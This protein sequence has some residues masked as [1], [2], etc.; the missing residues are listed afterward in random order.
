MRTRCP[1]FTV[2]GEDVE[3]NHFDRIGSRSAR[4]DSPLGK[5]QAKIP[6]HARRATDLR[7]PR[8]NDEHPHHPKRLLGHLVEMRVV[9]VRTVFLERELV[10]ECLARRNRFL[11]QPIHPVH[12]VG[13]TQAVPVDGGGRGEPVCHVDPHTVALH[14]LDRRPRCAP[15]VPPALAHQPRGKFVCHGLGDKVEHLDPV[16]HLV[17]KRRPVGRRH[18]NEIRL[19]AARCPGE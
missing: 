10:L 11:R 1:R 5:H 19:A 3:F 17:R 6:I 18:R 8:V 15:V 16:N 14:R 7:V 4:V 9:H 2:H 12:A 13:D